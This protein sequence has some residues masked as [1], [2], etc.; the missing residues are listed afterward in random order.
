MLPPIGEVMDVP[1]VARR[2]AG[3]DVLLSVSSAGA[4]IRLAR[5]SGRAG[6][7]FRDPAA[8]QPDMDDA[9]R[10]AVL[11][12]V[13]HQHPDAFVCAIAPTGLF[14]PLPDALPL[15]GHRP[16][17]GCRS[18]LDL[19]DAEEHPRVLDAWF[20]VR[21]SGVAN[22]TL[23]PVAAPDQAVRLYFVDMTHRYGVLV[24][25]LTGMAGDLDTPVLTQ[26]P[27]KPRMVTVRKD[28][29]ALIIDADP[30]IELVLGWPAADLVGRRSL[31]LVHPDDH[32]R[33]IASWVDMLAAPAGAAR[34][35]R[36]RHLHRDGHAIW[37]EI[38]NHSAVTDPVRPHVVAEM[39]DI[40]DE[41]AALDAL[42]AN[43]QLL[44]RLAETLPLGVLQIDAHR[45][46][47]YQNARVAQAVGTRAGD[48][49]STE[50]LGMIDDADRP[51]VDAAIETV[52][53]GG[54][55]ADLEYGYRGPAGARRVS[56]NLRV[57]T[58]DDGTVTGAIICLTD[59]TEDSR[60]RAELHHRATYDALTG[61]RNRASTL[62][63]L[64]ESLD[65]PDRGTAVMFVDLDSFKAVNDRLGHAAGD[66]LLAFVAQRLRAAVRDHDVIGRLGGDEFVVV[67]HD[68]PDTGQARRIAE[69]VTATLGAAS[70]ETA[71]ELL[72]PRASI[73]LTWVAPG[74]S[75]A[76]AVIAEAD[77]AMYLVKKDRAVAA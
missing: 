76:D 5:I 26:A 10:D 31:E 24:G 29:A 38:T 22:C 71:G 61:S 18:A 1:P 23:H 8:D 42:H 56:A 57:L 54:G 63:A 36:L 19:V 25:V 35:V 15:G 30:A 46:V 70:L 39:L 65:R 37:F 43:E 72:R 49:L 45:R 17:E 12:A 68:V 9:G 66:A 11:A 51:A 40:S 52:L 73:G 21:A 6:V 50:R 62:A 14:V 7:Q 32:Q 16:I 67:C 44:S 41:M 4:A 58:A 13:L 53:R 3:C 33:A 27:I 64:Q 60:L 59:I 34:R 47:V 75:D 28:P 2:H 77:A 69:A 48:V 74:R 20:Q 55:D